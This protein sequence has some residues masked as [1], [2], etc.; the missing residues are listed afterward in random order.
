MTEELDED[1]SFEGKKV[2]QVR[3]SRQRIARLSKMVGSSA[4]LSTRFTARHVQPEGSYERRI[5]LQGPFL[6]ST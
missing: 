4:F 3:E 2:R 1:R 5:E 6:F